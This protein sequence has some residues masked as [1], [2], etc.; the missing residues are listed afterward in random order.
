MGERVNVAY[1]PE[2]RVYTGG[3]GS[4]KTTK[5]VEQITSL[6]ESGTDPA[7][8][9]ALC[10]TPTAASEFRSRLLASCDKA[11]AINV[12]VPRE[13]FLS[14]LD[15]NAAEKATGRKARSL[16]PFE[17]HFFLED[18]KTSG[19]APKRLNEIMKFFMKGYTEL[20]DFEDDWLITK[21]ELALHD[22]M[23]SCLKFIQ[24]MLPEEV[25]GMC[26]RYLQSSADVADAC[27]TEYVFADDFLMYSRATQVALSM[28]ARTSLQVSAD[29]QANCEVFE[30]YPYGMGIQE[31][32][33]ANPHAN[34]LALNTSSCCDAALFA[35]S[36]LRKEAGADEAVA[37]ASGVGDSE[38]VCE[39]APSP[40]K[41]MEAIS[42]RVR[43]ALD[44][45]ADES[46]I[47]IAVP[48][49]TWQVNIARELRARG[50]EVST[51]PPS[52]LFAGDI[53]DFSRSVSARLFS[54]LMLIADPS[55]G[56]AWR[57][58]CGFGD[59]L[60]NSNG[61]S[62]LRRFAAEHACALDG[63]L[64]RMQ[65]IL[66]SGLDIGERLSCERIE[67]AYQQ[68][69]AIIEHCAD[70][71]GK[72][73]LRALTDAVCGKGCEIPRE[74][75][76]AC[77][78]LEKGERKSELRNDLAEGKSGSAGACASN[79]AGACE[80]DLADAKTLVARA[81]ARINFPYAEGGRAKESGRAI[82]GESEKKSA[83]RI[84]PYI[85]V[86]G[87]SPRVLI[88]SGFM[89]GFFPKHDYFDYT[90]LSVD[91]REKRRIEDLNLAAVLFGKPTESLVVTSTETVDLEPAERM[92]LVIDH[93]GLEEGKRMAYTQQS[94]LLEIAQRR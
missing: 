43:T 67:A 18:L 10:A 85:N 77:A 61:M 38:I 28:L 33:A 71:S 79:L 92:H 53:R 12:S 66:A 30:S 68:A 80:S 69:C 74:L 44:G 39:I 55:N 35:V 49:K 8:I 52:R 72:E 93:I 7:Q 37:S 88:I 17:Y 31:L 19:I 45:G 75:L 16:L 91:K 90:K 86:V 3:A 64:A 51:L 65:E 47:V 26:V 2:V 5:L 4:G 9:V 81:R 11:D 29:E 84:V 78:P 32:L 14:I 60:T 58:W 13:Y 1:V 94:E 56:V 20:S 50:I 46:D 62:A 76:V 48:H 73:L 54:A 25:A 87:L 6:L 83:V 27:Q 70:L 23:Q 24:A 36:A 59:Y 89:N 40:Q 34:A 82:E 57:A 42:K 63:A 22:L 15:C 41:E 21:E